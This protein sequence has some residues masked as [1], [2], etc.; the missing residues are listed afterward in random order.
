M[1]INFQLVEVKKVCRSLNL[2]DKGMKIECL[3]RLRQK[4]SS[5]DTYNK[6]FTKFA[7][8]SG[9]SIFIFNTKMFL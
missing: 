1:N 9:M 3:E 7:G 5:R 4:L 6:V 2:S 8:S